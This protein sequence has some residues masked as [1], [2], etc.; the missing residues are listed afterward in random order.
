LA[1]AGMIGRK[2]LF[3]MKVVDAQFQFFTRDDGRSPIWFFT[4]MA[5]TGGAKES[6]GRLARNGVRSRGKSSA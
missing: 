5:R 1:A 4:R 3:L 6:K 2:T